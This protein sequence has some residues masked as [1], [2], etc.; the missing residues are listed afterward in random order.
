[1]LGL[2]TIG[3]M[4]KRIG[5]AVVTLRRWE[6]EG[7]LK[8]VN[9]TL[10]GHRR[11]DPYV[12]NSGNTKKT[13]CYAR[14]SCSDQKED[15]AR[16]SERLR[17][18]AEAQHWPN[19][20]VISDLGSGLNYRK[21]GLFRLIDLILRGDVSRLII[22]NKDRLLRFGAELIFLFCKF[23]AVKVVITDANKNESFEIALAKDVLEVITVFSAKLYGARSHKRRLTPRIT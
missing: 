12:G 18:Y 22:E 16:Q 21:K 15:L 19:I 3:Q 5:V 20:E 4:A 1:M 23:R 13:I 6:R 11:Y 10:G 14:T 9:R 7:K 8:P 2:L 17:S